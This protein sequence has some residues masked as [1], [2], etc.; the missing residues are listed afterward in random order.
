MVVKRA[1]P[2][3]LVIMATGAIDAS[4]LPV[5]DQSHING[6]TLRESI[7]GNRQIAQT[8]TVGIGGILDSIVLDLRYEEVV[9]IY[10]IT[11][12]L[13]STTNGLPDGSD[14]AFA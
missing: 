3:F 7:Y 12:E 5:L 6:G 1:I 8:F 2:I 11:V 14:K 4:A 10:D 9:P 13:R